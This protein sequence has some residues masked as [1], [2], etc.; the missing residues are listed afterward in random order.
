MGDTVEDDLGDGNLAFQR[1][2]AG[3]VIDVEGKA[4]SGILIHGEL[5]LGRGRRIGS[6]QEQQ[7]PGA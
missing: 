7:S 2:T 4:G 1:F 6:D 3:L 5:D